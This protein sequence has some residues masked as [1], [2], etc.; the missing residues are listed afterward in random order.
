[1]CRKHSQQPAVGQNHPIWS[2]FYNKVL[3][4]SCNFCSESE[5][6]NSCLA[7]EPYSVRGLFTIT[8]KDWLGA[9]A[10]DQH[11]QTGLDVTSPVQKVKIQTQG[12][13]TTEWV[14][15]SHQPGVQKSQVEPLLVW[16]SLYCKVIITQK[17]LPY[18][19]TIFFMQNDCWTNDDT[20]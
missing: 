17:K 6:Q 5:K 8:L 7:S 10:T 15:Y 4:T 1:M 16:F 18:T 2:L 9:L 13:V 3:P 11:L 19:V 12:R 14:P 20:E